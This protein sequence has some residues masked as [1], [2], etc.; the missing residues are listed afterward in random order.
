[1]AT[2]AVI[3]PDEVA[4]LIPPVV[5]QA[6]QLVVADS[7]DYEMACSFLQLIA[8]RKKQIGEAFDPIVSKAHETHKEAVAQRKRLLDPLETAEQNVKGK[9]STFRLEE[10]RQ[11]RAEEFRLAEEEKKKREIEALEQAAHLEAAGDKEMAEMVI[12]QAAEAPAPV[13]VLQTAVPKGMGVSAQ[14]NWKFRIVNEALIP[15]EYLSPDEKKIGAV[16]RSQ[17]NLAKI[18]GIEIYSEESVRVRA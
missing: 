14:K 7:D 16:V 15:R 6:Q 8:T 3:S 13:V 1:M 11:R 9:V 5:S 10:E 2:V 18:P 17:K 12:Q 4:K